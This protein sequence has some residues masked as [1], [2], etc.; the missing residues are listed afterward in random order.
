MH[1]AAYRNKRTRLYIELGFER[2][3]LGDV[4]RILGESN[5][6]LKELKGQF[7]TCT[8]ITIRVFGHTRLSD[9]GLELCTRGRIF[10]VTN[11]TLKFDFG[12][13]KLIVTSIRIK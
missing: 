9:Y 3:T 11:S 4:R 1:H 13:F 12:S 7:R 10:I 6:T 5:A 2:M 8:Y